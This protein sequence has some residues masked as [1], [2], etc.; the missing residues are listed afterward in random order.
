MSICGRMAN[1]QYSGESMQGGVAMGIEKCEQCG[2]PYYKLLPKDKLCAAC[3]KTIQSGNK[4]ESR[5]TMQAAKIELCDKCGRPLRPDDRFCAACGK[6]IQIGIKAESSELIM[7]SQITERKNG[8]TKGNEKMM[9][10]F[11]SLPKEIRICVISAIIILPLLF[12]WFVWPTPWKTYQVSDRNLHGLMKHNR[13]TGSV[14]TIYP[15][16]A[17]NEIIYGDCW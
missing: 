13:I 4:N 14:C 15:Y 6:T 11:Q 3:E 12:G 8:R 5:A 16:G 2:R 10:Q 9:E 7:D 17:N 1:R